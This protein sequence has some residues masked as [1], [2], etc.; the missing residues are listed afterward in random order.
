MKGIQKNDGEFDILKQ[1]LEGAQP[2]EIT[3]RDVGW[4]RERERMLIDAAERECEERRRRLAIQR[5]AEYGAW[6]AAVRERLNAK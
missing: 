3:P 6:R 1:S 4:G 5:V 2:S